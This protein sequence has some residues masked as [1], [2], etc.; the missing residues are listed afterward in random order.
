MAHELGH[1]V[2]LKHP[3]C[4]IADAIMAPLPQ[5]T[6]CNNYTPP[7]LGPTANDILPTTSST[8]G[9]HMQKWCNF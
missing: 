8:Y 5:G 4:A 6:I 7:I 9:D 2:G 1:A 3:T